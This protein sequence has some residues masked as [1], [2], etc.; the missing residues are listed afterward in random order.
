MEICFTFEYLQGFYPG[1]KYKDL[2]YKNDIWEKIVAD[3]N[4]DNPEIH[5][6]VAFKFHKNRPELYLMVGNPPLML[7]EYLFDVYGDEAPFKKTEWEFN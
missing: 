1:V 3:G 6:I 7:D 2:E 5:K 4:Q